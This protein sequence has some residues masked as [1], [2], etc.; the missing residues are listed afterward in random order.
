MLWVAFQEHRVLH[1]RH[2]KNWKQAKD[3]GYCQVVMIQLWR[4]LGPEGTS[5]FSTP[6]LG[7]ISSGDDGGGGGS[8]RGRRPR[9][10]WIWM[11]KEDGAC[12]VDDDTAELQER[13][14]RW[15]VV[16]GLENWPSWVADEA[17]KTRPRS[18]RTQS[19]EEGELFMVIKI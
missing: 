16:V 11:H 2:A 6:Y 18:M 3:E 12:S 1:G 9:I 19:Q 15:W 13:W 17:K 4:G 10:L 5:L 14:R 7:S 8:R